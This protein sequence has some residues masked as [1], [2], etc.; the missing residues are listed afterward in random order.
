MEALVR[1]SIFLAVFATMA[2]WEAARPRRPLAQPRWE[3]WPTNLGLTL[4]NM[5]LIRVTVG[6]M[7]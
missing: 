3:R 2:L 4:L 7:A 1:L 6:G 5:V